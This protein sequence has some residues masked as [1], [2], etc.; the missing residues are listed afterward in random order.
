M[1]KMRRYFGGE[2]G[3]TTPCPQTNLET[4][5][6]GFGTWRKFFPSKKKIQTFFGYA[7][8]DPN[9]VSAQWMIIDTWVSFIVAVKAFQDEY[10]SRLAIIQ[11]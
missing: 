6:I 9:A 7:N 11:T 2:K 3:E 8:L 5:F 10:K 4:K 1:E